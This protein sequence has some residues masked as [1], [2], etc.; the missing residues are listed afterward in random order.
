MEPVTVVV[1][2]PRDHLRC[3]VFPW[4]PGPSFVTACLATFA[5]AFT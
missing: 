4:N 5:G 2:A 1:P 3:L